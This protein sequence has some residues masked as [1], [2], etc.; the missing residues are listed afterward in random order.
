MV[1]DAGADAI[2]LVFYEK[3][4][5]YVTATIAADI[6]Q[7]VGPFVT[8]VGLFVNEAVDVVSDTLRRTGI[9]V[10][11][12]HGDESKAYCEQFER[13]FIKAIRMAPDIDVAA[14]VALHPQAGGYLFDAWQPDAY[15][16]TGLVF[17]WERLSHD[18]ARSVI[19]AGGL[20]SDNVAAAVSQT[21]PYAVDVS[22][23]VESAPGIKDETLVQKFIQQARLAA[24]V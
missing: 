2:G 16:G 22:S 14:A 4:P 7:A 11:Q 12:F 6:V 1:A 10:L 23:G 3:S 24:I 13:P 17:D 15:G 9:Q 18:I 21:Q 8:T 20:T 19:L 5:R